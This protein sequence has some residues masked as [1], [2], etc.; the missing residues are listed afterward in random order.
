[1][2]KKCA[3]LG[4]ILLS[5]GGMALAW[6][7]Y[8][9]YARAAQVDHLGSPKGALGSQEYISKYARWYELAPE[10]QTRLVL[11]LDDERRSKTPERLAQEQQERLAADVDKLAA[12]EMVPNEIADFL[13]G[14][15][16]QQEVTRYR[17]R[18]G[19]TRSMQAAAVVFVAFGGGLFGL[20]ILIRRVL[21]TDGKSTHGVSDP[22]SDMNRNDLSVADC[23]TNANS[24]TSRTMSE[25]SC[26]SSK[27]L[28]MDDE[29]DVAMPKKR[30]QRPS[31]AVEVLPTEVAGWS[32]VTSMSGTPSRSGCST[33]A[34]S[35]AEQAD[36]LE[37]RIGE[38][39][40]ATET[41]KQTAS[42][43]LSTTLKELTE[44]VSAI[45]EYAACQQNRVERL[46]DGYDWGIIRTFCL[47]VIRCIDNIEGR[48]AELASAKKPTVHLEEVRDEL[49]FALESSGVEPFEPQLGS[50]Y[51]GQEKSVEAVKQKK[52]PAK[53]DQIGAIAKVIRPGYRYVMD[54][55]NFKIVRTAQVILFG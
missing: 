2:L 7:Y 27:A 55:E 44:Q 54:E 28:D 53:P 31:V 26:P 41:A 47:R 1:M 23:P 16:W 4:L 21:R 50:E 12:G 45:R 43:P 49:L 10:E 8:R 24:Q 17:E 29:P 37:R 30:A 20:I 33:A 18:D 36:D 25:P 51:R 13:Y 32:L 38:F 3:I 5:L 19:Q 11:E 42:E 6:G 34:E 40:T 39:R 52:K 15:N 9:T 14:P 46:Q 48:I 22:K 35:L